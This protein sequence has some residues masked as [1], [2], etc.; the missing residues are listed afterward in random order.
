MKTAT[1]GMSGGPRPA[2]GV[3]AAIVF[4]SA[5]ADQGARPA[6]VRATCEA[7]GLPRSTYYYQSHRSSTAIELEHRIVLRM[8][9]LRARMPDAGYRRMTEQLRAEGFQVNRKR[10]ARLMQLHGLSLKASNCRCAE[11]SCSQPTLPASHLWQSTRLTR[12]RQVWIADITYVRI[13]SNLVYVAAIVD[14]W[15]REVEGFAVSLQINSRLASIAL[16]AA[17]RAHRPAPGSIHHSNCG[18]QY[19]MRGYT[20]LLRRYG[21]VPSAGDPAMQADAGRIDRS[22]LA[23]SRQVLEL[24]GYESWEQVIGDVRQFIRVVYSPERIDALLERLP[25]RSA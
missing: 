17:V 13:R 8:H 15:L 4:G 19:V 21:L 20:D 24:A 16:H 12:P 1:T 3:P 9:E 22:R 25:V 23:I 7:I 5:A 11:D 10:I 2:A 18:T 6:S 14:A